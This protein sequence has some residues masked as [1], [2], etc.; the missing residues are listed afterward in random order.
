L[1]QTQTVHYDVL[2]DGVCRKSN[3][4]IGKTVTMQKNKKLDVDKFLFQTNDGIVDSPIKTTSIA[5]DVEFVE[6]G[7]ASLGIMELRLY[8]LRRHGDSHALR[9]VPIYL[10]QKGDGHDTENPVG[11]SELKP[12]FT[13]AYDKESAILDDKDASRNRKKVEAKRPGNEPWAIFRF[14]YR[15]RGKDTE[16]LTLTKL[17][18]PQRLLRKWI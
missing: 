11:Y 8:I 15:T 10:E 9:D 12:E 18:I 6:K 5:T 13:M 17:I 1:A 16:R 7:P 3:A 4:F 2:V 14:H